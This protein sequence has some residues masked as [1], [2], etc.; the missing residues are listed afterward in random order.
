MPHSVRVL[1]EIYKDMKDMIDILLMLPE[2]PTADSGIQSCGAHSCV[3]SILLFCNTIHNL[4]LES[5]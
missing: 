1:L 4:R 3:K 2:S 5:I